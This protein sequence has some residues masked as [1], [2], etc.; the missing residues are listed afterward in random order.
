MLPAG[1][2]IDLLSSRPCSSAARLGWRYLSKHRKREETAMAIKLL[3]ADVDGTLL[4]PNKVLTQE[5]CDAVDRL[6]AAGIELIVTSGRPPRGLASLI[7]PLK[8][9]APIAG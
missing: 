1:A 9:T 8:L 2:G 3:V 5:T 4:T 6:R 7:A